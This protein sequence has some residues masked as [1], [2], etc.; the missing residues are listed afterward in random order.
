MARKFFTDIDMQSESKVTNLRAG[1]AAGDAVNLSQLNAAI[2]GL[3]PKDNVRVKSTGNVNIASP[4]ASLNGVT[5]ASQD[6]VLLGD[7]TLATEN[8]I[9]VWNGAATPMTRAL[10]A[11]TFDKL[12]SAVV[13]VDEGTTNAQ[14]TWRQT[15][16]NGTIGVTAITW[17]PFGTNAP[18]ASETTPGVA[19]IATQPEVDAGTDNSRIVTPE[20]LKNY[21]RL[22]KKVSANIGDG[23]ATTYTVTHN[24]NTR[25]VIV[26]VFPNS[27]EY[28]DVEVDV[29]RTSVNAVALVFATAPATNAYRVAV[30]G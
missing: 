28:D 16:V 21:S 11:N 1:T 4:G 24:F 8:G 7:Q 6:R 9:Y 18:S 23:S 20:T 13:S 27:G 26:R 12:E 3:A 5:L 10:D 2:E 22:L 19:E 15:A 14:T 17:I 25:D 29:Q 30:I